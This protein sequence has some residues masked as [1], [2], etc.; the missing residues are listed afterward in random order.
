MKDLNRVLITVTKQ[1]RLPK[2]NKQSS[3]NKK[4][5]L[6]IKNIEANI[7]EINV[8]AR[9]KRLKKAPKTWNKSTKDE[10]NEGKSKRS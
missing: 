2:K 1:N 10:Q 5:V 3:E 8:T 4:E 9:Q 6:E 7:T